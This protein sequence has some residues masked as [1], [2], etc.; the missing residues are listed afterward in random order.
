MLLYQGQMRN[1]V[2]KNIIRTNSAE[3]GSG[4]LPRIQKS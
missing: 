2:Q 3:I 4:V 1:L